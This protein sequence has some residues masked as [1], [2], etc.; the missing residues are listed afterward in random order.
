MCMAFA[1]ATGFQ[2]TP[3]RE[4]RLATHPQKFRCRQ[5]SIH[6]PPRGATAEMR[7]SQIRNFIS[8]HAPPRGATISLICFTPSCTHFNSRPSARG[9]DALHSPYCLYI[10]ISIHAP[11]RG[12]TMKRLTRLWK[13]TAFQFTP[14]REGRLSLFLTPRRKR[15]H[16][17][18]RPSARGDH[19][20]HAFVPPACYFN[21]RPSARGDELAALA[22]KILQ[23]SIHAPPRGA[24][25]SFLGAASPKQF[26]FTPLRE[27]RRATQ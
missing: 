27:G 14:L 8:I 21:S 1:G 15:E 6:A 24:T 17:N 2:F 13:P 26:Q 25:L 7:N 18:S 5:I 22:R 12:A 9:D 16:F 4:G 10:H 11:P 20:V 23:I 19:P 3:L